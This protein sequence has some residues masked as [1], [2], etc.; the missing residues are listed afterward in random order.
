MGLLANLTLRRKL[1]VALTPLIAMVV[2]AGLYSSVEAKKIDTS[3]S[4]LIDN[5]IKS[6]YNIDAARSLVMRY[7]LFLYRLIVETDPAHMQ[8]LNTQLEDTYT[9]YQTRVAEAKRLYPAYSQEIA[10]AAARFEKAVADSQT[11]RTAALAN[12][13]QK[14]AG[15]MHSMVDEEME[16]ARLQAIAV[17]ADMEKAADKRSD[18][19]TNL[20][21]RSI[22]VTWLVLGLGM[23]GSFAVASYF[24]QTDVVRELWTI[25]DSIEALAVGELDHPIPFV[26][27]PN[28]IWSDW[29][30][31]SHAPRRRER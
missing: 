1:L 29:A 21:H 9:E 14:A 25:R 4:R 13:N 12:Q 17:A 23:V 28:E 16:Q 10:A 7:G 20:T 2:V 11:A 26:N 8:T 30:F 19:L 18:D 6:V 31:S 5:E 27:R 24:L 22:L 15:I 3:Y